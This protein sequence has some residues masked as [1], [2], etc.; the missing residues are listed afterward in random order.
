MAGT[1]LCE[2]SELYNILNQNQRYSRLTEPNFLCLID[3]RAE[4][5]YFCSHII[6]AKHA[7]WGSDGKWIIPA[8]VEVES[9][10]YIIVY[11]SNTSSLQDSGPAT[12][13]AES[14][15]KAS[16]HPVQILK[17]G[18]ERFCAIYPFFRTQKILYT[19][20]ELESLEP[21]PVEILPGQLYMGEFR[22]AANPQILKDLK[23][24]ALINVSDDLML[25]NG[26]LTVLHIRVSDSVDANLSSS[27][28]SVCNFLT[29]QLE[30]RSVAFIFS[31]HGISRCSVLAM[32]FLMHHLQY[33]LK[34]AWDHVQKCKANMRPNRG[35]VQQL[36][37]WELCVLGKK[38]TDISEPNY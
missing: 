34:E 24:T 35:F 5:P 29:S 2:P 4:G 9:M 17:G 15:A 10:R 12:D 33:T 7:K 6:T 37:S 19:I 3:T 32:A 11:D 28:E 21:Y 36:S 27:F 14:L 38:I 22:Q 23:L 20:R 18:Y 16:R 13:C 26:K 25:E 8:D 1:V 31:T 30:A